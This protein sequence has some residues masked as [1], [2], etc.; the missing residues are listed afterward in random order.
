VFSKFSCYSL[1]KRIGSFS[2][3]FILGT[4]GEVSQFCRISVET[5]IL[6]LF[7]IIFLLD[8][9]VQALLIILQVTFY[10]RMMNS[11]SV[12]AVVSIFCISLL[13]IP[14]SYIVN[15]MQA[16]QG[17]LG[18]FV[19]GIVC[20]CLICA[21]TYLALAAFKETKDWM[22]YGQRYHALCQLKCP[23]L[24]G[25]GCSLFEFLCRLCDS[26]QTW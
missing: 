6:L 15:T 12:R 16:T 20:L 23:H 11:S 2:C 9:A 13:G 8:H 10:Q 17:E 14:A 1:E 26:V 4:L 21:A 19:A 24:L 3:A 25:F 5:Q 7:V 18:L 22:F